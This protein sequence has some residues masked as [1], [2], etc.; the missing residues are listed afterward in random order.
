[1]NEPENME[2]QN[3][4][5]GALGVPTPKKFETQI[6]AAEDARPYSR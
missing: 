2:T 3:V 4:G 6:G 1:M 5:D